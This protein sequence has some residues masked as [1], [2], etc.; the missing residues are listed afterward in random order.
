MESLAQ[1]GQLSADHSG[2][3]SLMQTAVHTPRLSIHKE[4]DLIA[5]DGSGITSTR[6]SQDDSDFEGNQL[7]S[8]SDD[9]DSDASDGF[10]I[11]GWNIKPCP[12]PLNT[13]TPTRHSVGNRAAFHQTAEASRT[14]TTVASPKAAEVATLTSRPNKRRRFKDTLVDGPGLKPLNIRSAA[15]NG[16]TSNREPSPLPRTHR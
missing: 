4:T 8:D 7:D 16:H 13:T 14:A 2:R 1:G 12:A 6:P 10:E 11:T 15:T 5:H 9:D 3:Y